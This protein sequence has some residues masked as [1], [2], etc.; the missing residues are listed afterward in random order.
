M[1]YAT[2]YEFAAFWNEACR[3][4]SN[5]EAS[6]A[7]FDVPAC[8]LA[9]S[10]A[11][12]AVAE[13]AGCWTRMAGEV[14]P[15]SPKQLATFLYDLKKFPI[16]PVQGTLKAVKRVKPGERPTSEAAL[17]WLLRKSQQPANRELLTCLMKLRK[18]TKLHQFLTKLPNY[19]H[20]GL[21][22]ASFGPDTAT[23]RLSSRNPNLQNIPADRNDPFGI[24][25]CFTAPAGMKLLVADYAALE[26][27]ILAHFLIALFDD[28]SL[29]EALAT[30]DLYAAVAKRTWPSQL[31]GVEIADLKAHESPAVQKLRD[32]AKVSVLSTNYGKTAS[33]V[34]I[35]LDVSKA[36]ATAMLD[37]YFRAY[38]GIRKFQDW[39]YEQAC[40][41]GVRTLLG[42]TRE[43]DP[44]RSEYEVAKATRLATN[45]II[46]G[47]A[48][49]VV[50]GAMV[51][52]NHP[53]QRA[54]LQ[55]QV[56]DELVWR[57]P[58]SMSRS[59]LFC[60]LDS[61]EHPFDVDL[62]VPLIVDYK[63]VDHW[64]EGH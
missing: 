29:A 9:A 34:A 4:V 23:G 15:E 57:F 62:K 5:M 50:Y 42:R 41:G 46:Q 1:E 48:A 53:N 61:M 7:S 54:T 24:R 37:D 11:A 13:L 16:P 17:D 12:G 43:I 20:E 31:E 36:V 47:S 59:N 49:D 3:I 35:Q 22:Y 52:Q 6:G 32:H 8:N 28:H 2:G 26:P 19:T 14:N 56:H 40:S 63:E 33:G 51:K 27:R 55:L 60:L 38:P 10:K 44:G 18:T 30:G 25:A 21:L 45:T 39:A 64:G 58:N